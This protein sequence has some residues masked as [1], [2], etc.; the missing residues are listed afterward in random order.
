MDLWHL[1]PI[2]P[3]PL[4]L[5]IHTNAKFLHKAHKGQLQVVNY[6]CILYYIY[7]Q[8]KQY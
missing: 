2:A 1:W 3:S 4:G 6:T 7:L 8:F 5:T